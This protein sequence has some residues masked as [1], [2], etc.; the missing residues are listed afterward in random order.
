MSHL[1]HA[2]IGVEVERRQGAC[3][4]FDPSAPSLFEAGCAG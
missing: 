1:R 4:V 2:M 3:G